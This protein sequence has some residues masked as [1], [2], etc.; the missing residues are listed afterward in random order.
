MFRRKVKQGWMERIERCGRDEDEETAR[1]D[2][3]RKE[4]NKRSKG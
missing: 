2:N 1:Q 4:R 3:E